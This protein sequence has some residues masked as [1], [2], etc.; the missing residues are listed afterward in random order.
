[1]VEQDRRRCSVSHIALVLVLEV[2]RKKLTVFII[3]GY[4]ETGREK[5]SLSPRQSNQALFKNLATA[6]S[7]EEHWKVPE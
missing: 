3:D 2:R 6:L 5:H 7:S 4:Q 1:M